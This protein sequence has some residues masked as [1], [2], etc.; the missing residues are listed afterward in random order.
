MR[1]KALIVFTAAFFAVSCSKTE[2]PKEAPKSEI[3][4]ET[5]K[6]EVPPT[7][8]APDV[9]KVKFDTTKGDIVLE[10]HRDWAPLGADR[11]YE[12]V[13]AKFFDGER[14][15]RLVKNFI[16]QF[17]LNGDPAVNS[18]WKN[19]NLV[20]DPV[21]KTNSRGTITFATAGAGTR[22]TQLFINL[23][24]NPGLDSQGFAP[25]GK[26][27]EG[28]DVVDQLYAGYGQ[29]PEQGNIESQGNQ[30]LKE[31]FPKLDY[32]KKATIL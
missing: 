25:F 13:Q 32:I 10:I 14:F 23:N 16:V 22:T 20:D 2:P 5:P 19:M 18:K 15:F 24:N 31:H 17:G 27:I 4:K 7:A 11:F 6:A 1:N 29:A 28:M 8:K 30:Y 3:P 26:V 12:L 9:F 21:S